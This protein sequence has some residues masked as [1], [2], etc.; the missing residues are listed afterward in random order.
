MYTIP[1][2][3]TLVWALLDSMSMWWRFGRVAT[4]GTVRTGLVIVAVGAS[5][6]LLYVAVRL[7]TLVAWELGD[8]TRG[9]VSF[10]VYGEA[11]TVTIS[12]AL[13]AWGTSWE[14]ISARAALIREWLWASRAVRDLDPLWRALVALYPHITLGEG[15][16]RLP[17]RFGLLRHVVEIRDGI[18]ALSDSVDRD[19][20]FAAS[21]ALANAEGA[22]DSHTD[23]AVVAVVLH[24]V[25]L[26]GNRQPGGGGADLPP[27]GGGDLASEVAWLRQVATE[28]RRPERRQLAA[29]VYAG[30]AA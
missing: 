3:V 30:L 17:G 5:V 12:G 26:D 10:D 21:S 18:L 2:V 27:G 13:L 22:Q 6:G 20:A 28:Y 4:Q 15:R 25:S 11:V 7:A 9:W 19:M 14:T 29:R 8:E 23:A 16:R 1:C 24:V